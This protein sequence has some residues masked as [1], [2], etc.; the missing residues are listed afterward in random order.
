MDI[1]DLTTRRAGADRVDFD[2]G[3]ILWLDGSDLTEGKGLTVGQVTIKAGAQ[4]SEHY[5]PNCNEALYLLAGRLR[6]SLGTEETTLEPGDLLHVPRGE[7]HVAKSIG[8]ADATAVIVY[9]S[10]SRDIDFTDTKS[11]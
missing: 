8:T 7:P 10:D 3:H 6:H 2:W 5:H 9:D 11:G 4:N 1:A